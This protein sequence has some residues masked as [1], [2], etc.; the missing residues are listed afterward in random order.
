[1]AHLN[2]LPNRHQALCQIIVIFPHQPI[3]DHDV[4]DI[5]QYKCVLG[6]VEVFGPKKGGGMVAPVTE[7]V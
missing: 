3:R 4:V 1:M 6:G 7:G 5:A 2:L